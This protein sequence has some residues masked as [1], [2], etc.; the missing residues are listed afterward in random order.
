M[1][2]QP[3]RIILTLVVI[4]S[5]FLT[6]KA[7][8]RILYIIKRGHGQPDWKVIRQRILITPIRLIS[9]Q[10]LFR[11][12]RIPSFFHAMVGWGFLYFIIVNLQDLLQAF[13]PNY[14]FL[15][16]SI[17]ADLYSLGSDFFSITILLGMAALIFRRFILRPATL[18]ARSDVLLH[19]KARIGIMRDSAIVSMFVIFHVGSRFIGESFKLVQQGPDPWQPFASALS[20]LWLDLNP[21]VLTI[22]EH[23]AFWVSIGL[24]L[25]FL[26]YFLYSK[27]IHIFFAPINFLIKPARKSIGELSCLNFADESVETF[28]VSHLEDLSWEQLVDSYACTMCFRCQQVCPAY[29]TGKVLSP[30]ALEINKRYF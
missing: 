14:Q 17:I 18:S 19:P 28:G 10:P 11:F 7:A 15:G 26:P 20:N 16:G 30:A 9:F 2:T 4:L 29:N 8:R 5:L 22:G 21:V 12:R 1:L 27:H 3:E 24:I 6:F 23:I 13:I 25:A